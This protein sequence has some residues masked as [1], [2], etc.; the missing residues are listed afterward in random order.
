MRSTRFER[1]LT[2]RP[3][4][5]LTDDAHSNGG[6]AFSPDGKRVAF[7]SRRDEESDIVVINADG[8]GRRTV[9]SGGQNWYPRWSPDGR[10]LVYTAKV[11]GG[12]D[13]DLD[14]YAV[15]VDG[16]SSP[17]SLAS[18]PGREAEGRWRP[19]R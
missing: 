2:G 4:R 14:I 6:A 1:P 17:I 12:A 3:V 8:S 7:D 9:V 18:S 10:W 5:R 16:G 15:P 19:G 11:P 13:E